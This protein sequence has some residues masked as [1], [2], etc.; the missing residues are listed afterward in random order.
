MKFPVRTAPFL[1]PT[2]IAFAGCTTGMAVQQPLSKAEIERILVQE[3]IERGASVEQQPQDDGTVGLLV[4]SNRRDTSFAGC[5][6]DRADIELTRSDQAW[7]ISSKNDFVEVAL[8]S[9]DEAEDTGFASVEGDFSVEQLDQAV[10]YLRQLLAGSLSPEM[11][12]AES[13][14]LRTAVE[15]VDLHELQSV[16]MHENGDIEFQVVSSAISPRLLGIRIS[17]AKGQLKQVY[18][19]ADNSIEVVESHAL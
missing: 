4:T 7:S 10:R 3:K 15:S 14:E 1:A 18:L 13:T 6:V 5:M 2:L 9:C 17:V 11:I 8:V 16:F 19:N 12:S